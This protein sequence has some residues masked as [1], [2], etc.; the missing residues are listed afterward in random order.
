ME[1]TRLNSLTRR[2][3]FIVAA[4]LSASALL[5]AAAPA[6]HAGILVK[7]ATNCTYPAYEQ[8]FARWS[9]NSNYILAP[10]GSFENGAGGWSLSKA[11]VVS[12]NESYYVGGS[13]DSHSLAISAG[14]SAVSPTMCVGLDRPTLRFFARSSG[15]LL[16]LS[17]MAVSVRFE[18]S[19]G[20]VAELPVGVVTPNTRWSPTLPMP[21]L[22]SLLPLLPNDMT[23]V[24]FRFTPVGGASWWIDDVYVDP[25]ARG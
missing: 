25:R 17:T 12:G 22:A 20:L 18:T 3:R 9:D 10:N 5:F 7:S 1:D 8:P 13:S 23:P 11:S 21:V 15:G 2:T 6:A 19:L 4:A 16:S 24:Q 14:G